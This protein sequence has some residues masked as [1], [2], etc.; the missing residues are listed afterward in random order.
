MEV[1]YVPWDKVIKMCYKLA[2]KII[3]SEK[4]FDILIA[5]S[6]GGFI[7]ARIVSDVI[8]LDEVYTIRSKF[9]GVGGTIAPEPI[10]GVY[11]KMDIADKRILIVDDVVDTGSTLLKIKSLLEKIGAKSVSSGV[12]HYKT[13]SKLKP[14]YYVE[15][16]RK[17]TWIFYPWSLFE[18][19][20]SL[21]KS[22]KEIEHEELLN[23]ASRIVNKFGVELP[24]SSPKYLRK[25][26]ELY[27]KRLKS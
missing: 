10:L 5:V 20:Y 11:E 16:V 9:W 15:E 4:E 7:P 6:R 1:V 13:R 18:T 8:C 26:L 14:D 17:W 22:E 12:L 27:I 21:S 25:G 23:E 2:E 19:L 24:L 3:D